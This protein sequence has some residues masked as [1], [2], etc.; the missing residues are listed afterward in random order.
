MATTDSAV[1]QPPQVLG[2]SSPLHFGLDRW[3]RRRVTIR[4]AV[5]LEYADGEKT[6]SVPACTA[7]VN[8]EEALLVTQQ[9]LPAGLR[10]ELK[11][12]FTGERQAGH[13]IP[14]PLKQLDGF[15]TG[16]RFE[17]P[18]PGFWHIVFPASRL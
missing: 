16:I 17:S 9:E 14:S 1:I 6:I 15:Y 18:V 13:I 5:S 3:R 11:Q 4:I 10:V 12:S 8:D 7:W 2:K